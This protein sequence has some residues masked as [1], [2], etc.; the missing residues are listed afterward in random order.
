MFIL[1]IFTYS[2]LEVFCISD[3]IAVPTLVFDTISN[4]LNTVVK[5]SI[6][7]SHSLH[8]VYYFLFHIVEA[9]LPNIKAHGFDHLLC[10]L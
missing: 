1:T 6:F 3:F 10:C 2:L 5:V 9:I 4:K 8:F 7:I